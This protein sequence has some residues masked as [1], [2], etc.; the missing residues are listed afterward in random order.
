MKLDGSGQEGGRHFLVEVQRR[1]NDLVHI[2]GYLSSE[3]TLSH[4]LRQNALV[5]RFECFRSYRKSS[6]L[7]QTVMHAVFDQVQCMACSVYLGN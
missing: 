2:L 6:K 7:D 1:G 4:V 3:S 5:D